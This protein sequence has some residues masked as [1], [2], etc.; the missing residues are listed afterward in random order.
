M[1]CKCREAVAVELSM[2]DITAEMVLP[3]DVRVVPV[4]EL[5]PDDRKRLEAADDDLAI[6]RPRGRRASKIID[7]HTAALLQ[8]FRTARPIIDAVIAY[9]DSH[10]LD[11]REVLADAFPIIKDCINA[12]FLVAADSPEAK[13][14]EP[15][16]GTSDEVASFRVLRCVDVR[17]DSE[18]YQAKDDAGRLAALKILRPVDLESGRAKLDREAAV[19]RHLDGASS[20]RLLESGTI[21]QRPYLALAW[22][23]G[24]SP[25]VAAGEIRDRVASDQREKLLGLCCAILDAYARLHELDVVHADVHPRNL[26]L[27]RQGAATVLDFGL[28]QI[29]GSGDEAIPREGIGYFFEPEYAAAR[30]A[31]NQLPPAAPLG[32]QYAVA[33]LLYLMLTGDHYLEFTIDEDRMLGQIAGDRPLPFSSRG[34]ES[35]PEVETI[36]AKALRKDPADRFASMAAFA[37]ALRAVALSDRP[38]AVAPS[39]TKVTFDSLEA[40]RERVLGRLRTSASLYAEGLGIAPTSSVTYGAAGIAYALYRMAC[41]ESDSTLLFLADSW[42]TRAASADSDDVAFYNPDIEITLDTVGCVSPFHCA[43]GVH[44]VRALILQAMGDLDGHRNAL[45]AFVAASRPTSDKLDLTLGRAGTLLACSLLLEGLSEGSASVADELSTL[46]RDT[47]AGLWETLD[48]FDPIPAC[49]QL[50]NLGMAHGWAGVLFATLRW[51]RASQAELPKAVVPRLGELAECAEP[52]GRGARWPWIARDDAGGEA[53]AYMP[54][55]CN[56]SAGFVHLWTLAHRQLHRDE[57]LDLAEYAAWN[58]WEEPFELSTLCCG[59]AGRAYG[60]LNF[61]KH[62]G[63]DLWLER[64]RVLASKAADGVAA[65]SGEDTDFS[66]SLYKGDVSLAVLAADLGRPEASCMPFFEEEGWPSSAPGAVSRSA[67]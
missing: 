33:A 7:V 60:L 1:P 12:R 24:V 62:T 48:H 9:S 8:E 47:V 5:S 44:C 61:Y 39:V 13:R 28:A 15:M 23:S 66:H 25:L 4:A 38:G 14:I 64:A 19:L 52:A 58:V 41:V 35:W 11:P 54:G 32:E 49:S 59:L 26:L 50:T 27:D 37:D 57:Y 65:P 6:T 56:G 17:E 10:S 55:W 34:V 30:L 43:S 42:I 3:D 63:L 46:G 21:D 31:K 16:L 2:M 53:K 20:P 40:L 22:C 67:L 36:L 18:V 51:C 29:G 45:A